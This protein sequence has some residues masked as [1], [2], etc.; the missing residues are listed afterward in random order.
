M[1]AALITAIVLS[2]SPQPAPT[3]YSS[4]SPEAA[5]AIMEC[6]INR[7]YQK[8]LDFNGDGEL[9]IAD[10]VGV[11]K[12]YQDNCRYGN[13]I[14]L[15][16]G[17]INNIITENYSEDAIYWEIDRIDK[18]PTRQYEI[19][20]SEITTAEIYIEFESSSDCVTVEVNPFTE[21]ITV[22]G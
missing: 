19:T 8:Y 5:D 4:I 10:I 13:E 12:R 6:V 18:R 16:S 22:I 2:A 21:I 1:K 11:R 14:T 3:Y 7:D 20:V 15:D 17:I 9:N